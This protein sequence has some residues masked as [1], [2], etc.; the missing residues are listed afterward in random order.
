MV[1]ICL[2]I[3]RKAAQSMATVLLGLRSVCLDSRWLGNTTT[4]RK[5]VAALSYD[6]LY[7]KNSYN[8]RSDLVCRTEA[9]DVGAMRQTSN[10][11]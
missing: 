8:S 10:L 7:A 4:G 3:A 9:T 1:I 2:V 6:A 5:G 11:R